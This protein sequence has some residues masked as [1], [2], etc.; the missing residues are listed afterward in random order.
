[1]KKYTY[2]SDPKNIFGIK[3]LEDDTG[4]YMVQSINMKVDVD[5]MPTL[6]VE[7]KKLDD[8]GSPTKEKTFVFK[9]FDFEVGFQIEE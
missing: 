8:N 9:D 2:V 6:T 7:A 3:R 4:T 5:S 1:M